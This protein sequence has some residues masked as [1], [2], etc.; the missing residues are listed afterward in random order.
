M[1][2]ALT[3]EGYG[4]TA[5]L[6]RRAGTWI[7]EYDNFYSTVSSMSAGISECNMHVTG[8]DYPEPDDNVTSW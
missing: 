2:R 5:T 7:V 4:R 3:V 6:W 1:I 8:T